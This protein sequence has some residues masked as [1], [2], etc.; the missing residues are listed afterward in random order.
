MQI[1]D[2]YSYRVKLITHEGLNASYLPSFVLSPRLYVRPIPHAFTSSSTPSLSYTTAS[3]GFGCSSKSHS[4]DSPVRP[5]SRIKRMIP[6]LVS[7]VRYRLTV[8]THNCLDDVCVN[9]L[10]SIGFSIR[11]KRF[12]PFL[13]L[14]LAFTLNQQLNKCL[15]IFIMN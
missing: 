1:E 2:Q 8:T 13:S 15:S 9:V 3:V 4:V 12:F 11:E 7:P 5:Q 10:D 14:S 6:L